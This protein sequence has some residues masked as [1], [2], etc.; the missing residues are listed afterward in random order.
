MNH[1]SFHADVFT[2]G[3]LSR[4]TGIP[5]KAVREYT[6]QGL[7]NTIGRSP[8]GYRTYTR[9]ALRCLQLI[10]TLRGMGLTLREIG[11]LTRPHPQPPGIRLAA[12][13]AASRQR[14]NERIAALQA[15]LDRIDAYE[16]PH[17]PIGLTPARRP[18]THRHHRSTSSPGC[19]AVLSTSP[20]WCARS[21]TP[22][23]LTTGPNFGGQRGS[24]FRCTPVT[25]PCTTA[26]PHTAP[27]PTTPPRTGYQC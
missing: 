23:C 11:D 3:E 26:A 6:D 9:E 22:T 25:S 17:V 12:L 15:T 8:G 18:G 1:H 24:P 13:L 10:S 5:I 14:T 19:C 16:L 21:T 2:V 4:R 27:V 7:V 20:T